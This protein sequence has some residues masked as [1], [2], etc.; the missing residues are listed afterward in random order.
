MTNNSVDTYGLT[1]KKEDWPA[2]PSESAKLRHLPDTVLF[3]EGVKISLSFAFANEHN[4]LVNIS[5]HKDDA[6]EL[7]SI[8]QRN[9]PGFSQ[10]SSSL[11]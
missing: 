11:S 4:D 1:I 10:I 5:V 6:L 7:L 3:S 2:N 9:F 8:G